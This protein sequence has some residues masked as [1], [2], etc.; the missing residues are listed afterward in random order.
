M[1][2]RWQ[3]PTAQLWTCLEVLVLFFKLSSLPA[4]RIEAFK[5]C[6]KIES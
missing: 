1:W 2:A 6:G 4:R 3:D 5:N